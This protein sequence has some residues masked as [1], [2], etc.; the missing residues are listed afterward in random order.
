MTQGEKKTMERQDAR[1]T[2]MGRRDTRQKK[3]GR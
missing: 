3:M 1:Q 2:K